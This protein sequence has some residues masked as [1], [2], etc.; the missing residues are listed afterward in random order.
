MVLRAL[1][2]PTLNI[3]YEDG[4]PPDGAVVL[5]LHGWPDDIRGWSGVT[6]ALQAAGYRT[7]TP[8]LRGFGPTCFRSDQT[9]RD[10]RGVALMQDAVDLLNALDVQRCA[11]VGHDWGARV[12]YT[13][14]A[15]MPERVTL[16]AA[17]A[18]AFQ[19]GGRF[20]LP[21]FSQSRQF[22]Y[23]WFMTLDQGADA[24][25]ADPVGFARLQW[26][27]WS[28]PG[29][30][31]PEEF[32]QTSRSF[33]SQDWAE[34]TL[35]AYRSRW[36]P[37]RPGERHH[38][39]RYDELQRQLSAI[40]TIGVPTLMIQGGADTCDEPVSSAGLEPHFLGRYQRVV[41]NGVGHFPAREAPALVTQ[42]LLA[43]LDVN[44]RFH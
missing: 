16:L 3:T 44:T 40:E 10:G 8:Y 14:A 27:T 13:L 29:W 32:E 6:P 43:H 34:I 38:D 9:P 42:A 15:L 28:P 20:V 7:I 25:R 22:W 26:E 5:L 19:P 11:V 30:F 1:Q 41:L 33:H 39:H 18:L 21:D 2:T 35:S 31:S 17:L 37:E 23:Q 4:G 12:A 36:R 24:V